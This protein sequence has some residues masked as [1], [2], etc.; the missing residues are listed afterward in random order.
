MCENKRRNE[1]GQYILNVSMRL[2]KEEKELLDNYAELH[3]VT[4]SEAFKKA[5]FEKIEDD[6]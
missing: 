2:S 3:A 1:R 5:L 4:L 6:V